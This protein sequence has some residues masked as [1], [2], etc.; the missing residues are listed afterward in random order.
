MGG[1][2]G[3]L[4]DQVD[5]GGDVAP[6]VGATHLDL[7]V[8]GLVQVPE[9]VG[10]EQHVAELGVRDAG[11]TGETGLDR[12]LRHHLVDRDVLA[13]VAEEVEHAGAGG[14][15]GVVDQR[16]LIRTWL[17]VE[18]PLQLEL[19]ARHVVSELVT[20]EQVALLGL[21]ARIA[22][23]ARRP[24]G[25]RERP[26]ARHLEPPQ[27]ELAHQVAGVQGIGRRIEADVDTDRPLVETRPEELQVGRV[28]DQP[29]P[30]EIVDQVHSAT[31]DATP[32]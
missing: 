3:G 15:V 30:A 28:V 20:A 7:D 8:V 13:D 9:V 16:R 21:A 2:A 1:F 19:D 27:P 14:P 10:L 29:T 23:H 12:L 31:D 11:V 26:M 5:P 4:A 24:A 18:D 32:A 6:L 25:E 17:E 22:D